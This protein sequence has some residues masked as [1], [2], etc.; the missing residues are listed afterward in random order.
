MSDILT[1]FRAGKNTNR[2]WSGVLGYHPETQAEID[3]YGWMLGIMSLSAEHDAD[4]A[5]LGGLLFDELQ[6]KYFGE[7]RERVKIQDFEDVVLS[8]R[9][10]LADIM[11]RESQLKETGLDLQLSVVL[12]IQNTLYMAVVG[13][14]K[15]FIWREGDFAEIGAALIDAQAEGFARTGSLYLQPNDR[16]LLATDLAVDNVGEH[17]L[18]V[19]LQHF[20]IQGLRLDDG[21]VVLLTGYQVPED[22][23]PVKVADEAIDANADSELV[24]ELEPIEQEGLEEVDEVVESKE[25]EASEEEY[26][27]EVGKE[28]EDEVMDSGNVVAKD[29]QTEDQ[30]YLEDEDGEYEEEETLQSRALRVGK[31]VSQRVSIQAKGLIASGKQRFDQYRSN[32]GNFN[33]SQDRAYGG[34]VSRGGG[35]QAQVM[36]VIQSVQQSVMGLLAQVGLIKNSRQSYLRGSKQDKNWRMLVLVGFIVLVALIVGFKKLSQDREWAAFVLDSENKLASLVERKDDLD[37]D[38]SAATI[39]EGSETQTAQI[40][41]DIEEL[42]ADANEL[43]DNPVVGPK[44]TE[45][46]NQLGS[47]RDQVLK[48]RAFTEPQVIADLG[49]VFEGADAKDIAYSQGSLYIVD[50]AR[51]VVYRTGTALN[52][53]ASAFATGFTNPYLITED[54]DGD[55]VVVDKASDQSVVSTV[56]KTSGQVFR[57]PGLSLSKIGNLIGIDVWNS[58]A[59]MYSLSNE[60]Q[61]ILKQE[62]VG[63]TFQLPNDSSPWLRDASF[64][65]GL[66]IAADYWLYVLIPS[67]GIKRYLAGEETEYTIQGLPQSDLDALKSATAFEFTDTNIYIADKPNRRIIILEKDQAD[68]QVFKFIGQYVYRGSDQIFNNIKDLVVNEAARQIFVLDGSKIIRLDK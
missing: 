13:E 5:N 29:R 39:G 65:Q 51:G 50:A 68:A 42:E 19:S 20:D 37:V 3:T 36:N 67:Q 25:E 4:L 16:I 8:V 33:T 23:L 12:V 27:D 34:N 47:S 28:E 10:R 53:E 63:G 59:A 6:D 2:N 41:R 15:I 52:G 61:A 45:L 21:A 46:I 49:A 48:V 7:P 43:I 54:E 11:E 30:D 32:R 9:T 22:Q 18:E 35:V 38:V 40:V 60:K 55:L 31:D 17:T 57:H 66:D 1:D 64:A 58:N 62:S 56:N 14:S 26:S 44:V 24:L